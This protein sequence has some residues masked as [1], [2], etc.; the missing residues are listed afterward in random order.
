MGES[1]I[2]FAPKGASESQFDL[3]FYKHFTATRFSQQTPKASR[4]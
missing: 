1:G 3:W 4:E 2:S